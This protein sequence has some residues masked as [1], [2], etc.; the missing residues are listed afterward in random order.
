MGHRF[1]LR[2]LRAFLA[3]AE[4]LHF[5]RAAERL[6]VTQPALTQ[7]IRQLEE[8]LDLH[9]FIRTTRAVA[10]SPEG[11][12]LTEKYFSLGRAFRALTLLALAWILALVVGLLIAPGSWTTPLTLLG[13][14]ALGVLWYFV[15]VRNVPT[16]AEPLTPI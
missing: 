10:L 16:G 12:R 7:A 3:L 14:L 4:D 6:F 13:V 15:R 8:A 9:L 2:H 11:V 1:E 5:G